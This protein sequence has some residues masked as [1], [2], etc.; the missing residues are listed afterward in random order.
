M[1]L[2]IDDLIARFD[3]VVDTGK[4]GEVVRFK[5]RVDDACIA[6]HQGVGNTVET[7]RLLGTLFFHKGLL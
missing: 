7:Q 3:I 6:D 5:S 1:N 4:T 2:L